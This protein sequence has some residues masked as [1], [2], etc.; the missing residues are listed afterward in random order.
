MQLPDN[1]IPYS[2]VGGFLGA[3]KTT[4]LNRLLR[5]NRGVRYAVLVNDFGRLNIDA[6]LIV[7]HGGAT[8]ALANGC[9]CCSIADGLSDALLR[10]LETP[11]PCDHILVEASGVADPARIADFALL[12]PALLL[13]GVIVLADA[14]ALND[15]LDD[16]LIGDTVRRQLAAAD[17][18]VLNK[19]DL[20]AA[21]MLDN[22]LAACRRHAGQAVILRAEQADLPGRLLFGQSRPPAVLAPPPDSR[23]HAET[24]FQSVSWSCGGAIERARFDAFIETLPATVV[25]GKGLLYFTDAPQQTMLW[26]RCGRRNQLLP[27]RGA[28]QPAQ[29]QLVL[30]GVAEVPT[31]AQLEQRLQPSADRVMPA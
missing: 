11:D 5:D 29:T 18:V 10:L 24:L 13:D 22:S 7:Q 15:Q 9:I 20:A 31:P 26:Q 23:Q 6:E 16:R 2:V 25:R 30:I 28:A 21:C 14:A 12:D 1:P 4:L 17:I 8:I 3:G 27:W 19:I